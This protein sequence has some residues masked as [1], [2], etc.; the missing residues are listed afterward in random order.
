MISVQPGVLSCALVAAIVMYIAACSE[1]GVDV[2]LEDRGGAPPVLFEAAVLSEEER[3]VLEASFARGF[4]GEG[5][6]AYS[7]ELLFVDKFSEISGLD[8]PWVEAFVLSGAAESVARNRSLELD[9][10]FGATNRNHAL[11]LV[12]AWQVV[13]G[14]T[15]GGREA[16]AVLRQLEGAGERSGTQAETIHALT[17]AVLLEA[18][19]RAQASQGARQAL[20]RTVREDFKRTTGV[21]FASLQIGPQ[22]FSRKAVAPQST[23]QN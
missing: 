22:G 2:E 6:P 11:L 15:V 18:S 4:A 7:T 10:E 13:S 1:R 16:E 21:D 12:T 20:S 9:L 17:A 5:G 23:D 14:K 8:A 19:Y 3:S